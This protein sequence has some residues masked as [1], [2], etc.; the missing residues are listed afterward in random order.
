MSRREQER[1]HPSQYRGAF[2]STDRFEKSQV[3]ESWIVAA[4]R[5]IET[6]RGWNV[7]ARR[8]EKYLNG[9][10]LH[11]LTVWCSLITCSCI[12]QHVN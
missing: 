5:T 8:L 11:S 7:K 4:D 6:D 10:I 1:D 2:V 3:A 9:L 12:K